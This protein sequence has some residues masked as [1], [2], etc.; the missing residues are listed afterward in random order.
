MKADLRISN[1]DF[2]PNK[3]LKIH[4]ARVPFASQRKSL[5]KSR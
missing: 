2:Q 5:V 3:N 4:L 1:K